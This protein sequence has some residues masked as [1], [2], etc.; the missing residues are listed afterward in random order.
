MTEYDDVRTKVCKYV[1][2]LQKG[3]RLAEVGRADEALTNCEDAQRWLDGNRDMPFRLER[4]GRDWYANCTR[5]LAL[6]KL[7]RAEEALCTFQ[8]AYSAFDSK[9]EFDLQEIMRLVPELTDAGASEQELIDIL[10]SKKW[11]ARELMPL[12]VCLKRRV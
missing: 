3:R 7:G 11:K 2:L 8:T 9:R 4:W 5:S 12:I 10:Q 6:M 1:V